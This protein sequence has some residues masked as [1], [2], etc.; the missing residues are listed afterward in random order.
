[1]KKE[2]SIKYRLVSITLNPE[3]KMGK[4]I[5]QTISRHMKEKR[6]TVSSP[7]GFTKEFWIQFWASQCKRDM[8]LLEQAQ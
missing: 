2:D 5:R 1:M 4:V 3:K 6:V 8:E 7:H